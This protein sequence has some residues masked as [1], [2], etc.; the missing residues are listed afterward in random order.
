MIAGKP[1]TAAVLAIAAATLVGCGSGTTSGPAATP[2]ATKLQ[3]AFE[4]CKVTSDTIELADGN[5][6]VLIDGAQP[7]DMADLACLLLG[8]DTP[9][10]IVSEMDSTTSM[11]GRQKEEDGGISYDWSYHPDNGIDMILHED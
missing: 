6:S 4:G 10:Y 2:K 9:Q 5:R 11:M 3:K 7:E 8:L 1:L